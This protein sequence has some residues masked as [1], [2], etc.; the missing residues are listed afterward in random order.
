MTDNHIVFNA[1]SGTETTSSRNTRFAFSGNFLVI[2]DATEALVSDNVFEIVEVN[3]SRE[4]TGIHLRFDENAESVKVQN[5]T[6]LVKDSKVGNIVGVSV[7]DE[8][9]VGDE[10]LR[11]INN[12]VILDNSEVGN[13]SSIK[14]TDMARSQREPNGSLIFRGHNVV[15]GGVDGF[16][17][18]QFDLATATDNP[19]LTIDSLDLS[20]R[21]LIVNSAGLT[22]PSNAL[23]LVAG[24]VT[25]NNVT[26]QTAGTFAT[27]SMVIESNATQNLMLGD[28]YGELMAQE[29]VLSDSTL[30]LSDS[31]LATV[32][33]TRLTS[34]EALNLLQSTENLSSDAPLKGFA[35]LSGSSNFYELGT[36]FDLNGTSLTVGGA[37]RINDKWSG[38]GFANFS[39]ANADSTVSGFRGDSDMK[40]YSA[41]VALRYQTEMPFYTEG[42]LVVG[43]ADTDFVGYYTNDTA[44]YDS[45]RFYTTAQLGVGTNFALSDNVNLNVYGRYSFTYLDG[46]KVSLN[47]TYN[48]T[49]DV[50]DTMVHAMRVGARVKGSV[51]PNVQWFAGAAFE[52]VLDGDVEAMV[53]DAKLKT[54]TLKGNVGI[55]EVGATLAPNGLGPWTMDVKAG[56]YAGDRRGVSGSVSVNY[57]F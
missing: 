36:G 23:Q 42:A 19:M 13:V 3:D 48:D 21:T 4:F 46:D 22:S 51:A 39:D 18:F 2:D 28:F 1:L 31:Q 37:L 50:D 53:K 45:K 6:L 34:E 11:L 7:T 5:N 38:V 55:F 52:R 26:V 14:Y 10:Q 57:V 56:A 30:T 15:T 35:T 54:E 8:I 16:D 41:G 33:L 40:T 9:G 32:A 47:N 43:Q 12:K 17:T 25:M 49:F 27:K 20:D 44:R 24:D 29:S